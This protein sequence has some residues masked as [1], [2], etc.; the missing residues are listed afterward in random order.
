MNDSHLVRPAVELAGVTKYFDRGRVH[1]LDGIDLTVAEG[2]R[3]A[4][5]GP[6]GC[7]KS[8][9]LHLIAALDKPTSGQIIVGSLDLSDIHRLS[10]YRRKRVGLVFQMH[11]LLPQLTAVQNVEIAMVGTDRARRER[12]QRAMDLLAQVDLEGREERLPTRL[13][14][15]ERQRVAIARALANEPDLL[16]ADE[17]T[18]SLDEESIDR[19]LNLFAS[20]CTA[21]PHLSMIIVT[22]D[23]R[24][25]S[26]ADRIVGM[27]AGRIETD[28]SRPAREIPA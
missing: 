9:M 8:T 12:W 25:A 4:V 10:S 26:S 17:P 3:V 13:S 15:G 7:G 16:L 20:L 18:G 1:A 28:S 19:V 23:A 11:H 6:S 24:V 14:G 27:R 21:R 22:H 5:A 2:E